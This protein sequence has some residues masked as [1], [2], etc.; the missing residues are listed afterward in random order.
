MS[1]PRIRCLIV[2]DE[3]LAITVLEQH[4]AKVADVEVVA[5]HTRAL[6]ALAY[7][8]QHPVDLLF[9]DIQMPDL[10][11]LHLVQALTAPPPVI[12]TTAYRT[13]ALEGFEHDA[14]DY[15]LKPIALPR[16]LRALDKYRRLHK[17]VAASPPPTASDEPAQEYLTVTV[18]RQP[19]NVRLDD[20]R[21]IES[22]SDYVKIHTSGTPLITKER[23]SA[24]AEHLAPHGFVR[25]HRSFLVAQHHVTTFTPHE[26]YV[27][28]T[29]LPISRSYRKLAQ[30]KLGRSR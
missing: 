17:G 4:L 26:V 20:I 30:A 2:D 3:P 25:I 16:L 15:L 29:R 12:F 11:G 23:I 8:Q 9:L 6:D 13:Y 27:E 19:T 7:L 22:L 28:T 1:A 14:V 24:L 5:T 10:T 21:Y 18:Q